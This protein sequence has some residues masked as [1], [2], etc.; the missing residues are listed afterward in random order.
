MPKALGD[1][2]AEGQ[3]DDH[4]HRAAIDRRQQGFL[5]ADE[6]ADPGL[7]DLAEQEGRQQLHGDGFQ[8]GQTETA[9]TSHGKQ[10]ARQK[11]RQEHADQVRAGRRHDRG[12]DVAARH[13]GEGDR[14]LYGRGQDAEKQDPRIK[15]RR[16]DRFRQHA[17][18][19]A[20][21]GKERKG[22]G[23][24]GEVQAPVKQAGDHHLSRQPGAMQEEEQG[25]GQLRG[26]PEP[27]YGRPG[28][29]QQRGQRH[30][31]DQHQG[32]GIRQKASHVFDSK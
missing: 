17:Q 5:R 2:L 27:A 22:G 4:Q 15:R 14:R 25:D 7:Q 13:G 23:D 16:Q 18:T 10:Q 29:R 32:K 1:R 8:G 28:N 24:D 12:R 31:G 19:Q 9:M 11:G 3:V 21:D 26:E 20:E 6:T 30:R